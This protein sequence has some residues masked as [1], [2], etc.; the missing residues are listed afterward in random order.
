MLPEI[1]AK[2]NDNRFQF[3]PAYTEADFLDGR[4]R[5]FRVE[6][7]YVLRRQ[8]RVAGVLGVWDQHSFRQTVIVGYHGWLGTFRPL[9]NLFRR[10]PLPPPGQALRFFY[11]TFVATDD[12]PAY[13]A[14]LRRAYNDAV[15]G[16]HTHFVVSLHERDPRAAV[17]GE[18]ARTPFGGRL[19]AVT[20]DDPP[21]LDDRIPY[22]EAALL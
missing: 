8:G 21:D 6:D 11:V 2:L 18:Y 3:A 19:F 20:M 5:G 4:L 14:L 15:G 16:P 13:A 12:T 9:V 7:F 17:L 1:V 10:P 22:V